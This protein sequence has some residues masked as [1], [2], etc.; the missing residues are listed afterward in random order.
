MGGWPAAWRGRGEDCQL[1][2]AFARDFFAV[3]LPVALVF[4]AVFLA[5]LLTLAADFA[6]VFLAARPAGFF[7]LDL[8]P[9]EWLAAFFE[10]PAPAVAAFPAFD[11]AAF[12]FRGL[13]AVAACRA[14]A[15]RLRRGAAAAAGGTISGSETRP[16]AASGT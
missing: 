12:A 8:R 15:A 13:P 2:R 4:L 3:F 6:A 5:V 11:F 14:F 10:R 9:A 16:S 1:R 7:A